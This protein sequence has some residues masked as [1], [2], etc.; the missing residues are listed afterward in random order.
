M[1]QEVFSSHYKQRIYLICNDQ[2]G[3]SWIGALF[4]TDGK[5]TDMGVNK[6]WIKTGDLTTSRFEHQTYHGGDKKDAL[7]GWGSMRTRRKGYADMW[8]KYLSKVAMIQEHRSARAL[9]LT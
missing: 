6:N 1:D 3:S 4:N 2:E 8:P 9:R 7:F 5:L